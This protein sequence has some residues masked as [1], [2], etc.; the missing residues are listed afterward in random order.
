MQS[1]GEY[2]FSFDIRH[3]ETGAIRTRHVA[4]AAAR[5]A[6]LGRTITATVAGAA[7]TTT[8]ASSLGAVA[9][10]VTRLTALFQ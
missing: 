6:G 3:S 8:V 2:T 4:E 9:G 10:H 7:V 5:V 1:P